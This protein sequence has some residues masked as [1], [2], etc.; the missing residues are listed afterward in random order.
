MTMPANIICAR[1]DWPNPATGG[2]CLGCGQLLPSAGNRWDSGQTHTQRPTSSLPGCDTITGVVSSAPQPV[3]MRTLQP[4]WFIVVAVVVLFGSALLHQ[5]VLPA[6]LFL[7]LL[8]LLVHMIS[9]RRRGGGHLPSELIGVGLIRKASRRA[10]RNH[11]IVTRGRGVQLRVTDA[12]RTW[13]VSFL[14]AHGTDVLMGDPIRVDG[15]RGPRGDFHAI[16]VINLR[17]GTTRWSQQIISG[18]IAAACV[19]A[20]TLG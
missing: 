8:T 16:R 6:L 4:F 19:A 3:D 7:L 10:S 1:C 17:T 9:G 20:M 15:R 14:S 12:E 13:T 11:G 5:V 2:N 18:G